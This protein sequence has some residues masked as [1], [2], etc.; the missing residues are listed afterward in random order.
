MC[1]NCKQKLIQK[2]EYFYHCAECRLDKNGKPNGQRVD[3]CRACIVTRA[4][5]VGY[6]DRFRV[7][8]EGNCK[9]ERIPSN[10]GKAWV[11]HCWNLVK[12]GKGCLSGMKW[13]KEIAGFA[14]KPSTTAS[15]WYCKACGVHL[16]LKCCLK[17]R[18]TDEEKQKLEGEKAADQDQQ[19]DSTQDQTNQLAPK[20]APSLTHVYL[21]TKMVLLTH[22]FEDHEDAKYFY[23]TSEAFDNKLMIN[24]EMK[25]NEKENKDGKPEKD[26]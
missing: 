21:Q 18:L 17:H 13:S 22:K 14:R 24:K 1:R 19:I 4:S 25:V 8:N 11:C 12:D 6:S 20:P 7:H 9:M 10:L 23:E 5:V 3:Y 16:C 26:D 15:G 2:Q